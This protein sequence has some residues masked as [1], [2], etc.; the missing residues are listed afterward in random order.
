MSMSNNNVDNLSPN[1]EKENSP[2]VRG[3]KQ[4]EF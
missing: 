3:R 1:Y 2:K 4:I